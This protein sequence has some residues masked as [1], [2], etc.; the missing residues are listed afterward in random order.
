MK[1][2]DG[3]V[4][5]KREEVRVEARLSECTRGILQSTAGLSA[6]AKLVLLSDLHERIEALVSQAEQDAKGVIR[7]SK[8]SA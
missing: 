3:V 2:T 5:E 8:D 1:R 4:L 6:A 7:P